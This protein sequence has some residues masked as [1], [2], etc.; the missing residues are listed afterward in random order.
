VSIYSTC[1]KLVVFDGPDEHVFWVQAVPGHIGHP[2]AGYESD[3]YAAFLPPV[4]A[5]PDQDRALVV[6]LDGQ[7]KG[8][9]RSPQEYPDPACVLGPDPTTG[10]LEADIR[11]IDR[12]CA[13]WLRARR[14]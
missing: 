4:A 7:P 10:R 12:R 1:C 13:A 11:D 9:A 2:S 6:V 8:T 14:P 5:D 3:P